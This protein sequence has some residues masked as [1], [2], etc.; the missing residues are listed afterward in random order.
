MAGKVL[1]VSVNLPMEP[2]MPLGIASLATAL[3]DAGF[4]VRLFDTTFYPNPDIDD[5]KHRVESRQIQDADYSRYGVAMKTT[6]MFQDFAA[7]VEDYAP[8]LIGVGCVE[9][10]YAL[11]LRLLER[12][13][14]TGRRVPVIMGGVFASFS[15]ELV[16]ASGLVDM[17]CEGDG[18]EAIVSVAQALEAR[19]DPAGKVPNVWCRGGTAVA[20]PPSRRLV[21][22]D[23]LPIP[24]FDVFEPARIYRSMAG[25]VYRM[26][27]VEISRGC[28]YRC[29]YCSAPA[30]RGRFK[31]SGQWLRF[32]S[33]E[34]IL[35]EMELYR[36]RH[37]A[38]YFYLVSETFLA[39]P[40]GARRSFYEG[41]ARHGVP[42]WFNTRPE[43]VREADFR[44]LRGI[45]CHRI[46]MG[47]E[48]GSE[49]F[50]RGMLKRDYSNETVLKAVDIV[51]GAG[52]QI[53]VNN[54]IGFPDETREL[55]FETIEMNRRFQAESH[56][57]SIFQPFR[58][59]ELF[60]YCVRKGYVAAD[61]I[62]SNAFADS[63]LDMPSIGSR[64]ISGLYRAF[65]LYRR[66]DKSRWDEV[67][68]AEAPDEEGRRLLREL[69]EQLPA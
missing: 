16:L 4:Q 24:R 31:T 19:A 34:R 23:K 39:M 29:T 47:L 27:P 64:E 17:V 6:D 30:Y 36:R 14:R 69:T 56:T 55:I 61:H 62:C 45:G 58:G 44:G 10:T 48:S 9:I 42:F 5:Q 28:P 49:E 54:M 63:C 52:I 26:V 65:N 11:A 40:E 12:A 50:R 20:P 22:I 13:G 7:M 21:P 15:P 51:R 66:L 18:E 68:R 38:E 46:S 3:E 53:S 33:V 2:L 35:S 1:L 59:T 25:K 41:Y 32:K 67:R 37:D 8:D 57:V 60:D 43:T